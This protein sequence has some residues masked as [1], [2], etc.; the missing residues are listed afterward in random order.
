MLYNRTFSRDKYK[1]VYSVWKGK[2][3]WY[4]YTYPYE[5]SAL[6]LN[7]ILWYFRSPIKNNYI[8][9]WHVICNNTRKNIYKMG[10]LG[11]LVSWVSNSWFQSRPR[12][13]GSEIESCVGLWADSA[14]SVWHSRS[15]SLSVPLPC[16]LSLFQIKNIHIY[17]T[18]K[19]GLWRNTTSVWIP[20]TAVVQLPPKQNFTHSVIVWWTI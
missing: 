6:E 3:T 9:I 10:R 4:A 20:N 1:F 14:E 17:R 12:S 11:G 2:I 18:M 13:Q 5:I 16:S 15:P 19:E 7:K 8:V